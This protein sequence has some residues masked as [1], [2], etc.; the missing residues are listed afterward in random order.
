MPT[1][2]LST[3]LDGRVNTN[4]VTYHYI[5]WNEIPGRSM[6]AATS[7]TVPA[8]ATTTIETSRHRRLHDRG[9]TFEP[10]YVIVQECQRRSLR[11][12]IRRRSAEPPTRRSFLSHRLN[13]GQSDPER[14]RRTGSRSATTADVNLVNTNATTYVYYAWKRPDPASTGTLTAV[15]LTAFDATRYDRGVL[16][17]W[18]TGYEIDNLG[19]HVYREIDGR[20]DA[21]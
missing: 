15:R 2:S 13:A 14:S 9:V 21:A 11:F 3:S 19:F 5:A 1:A 7:A 12:T 20:A 16:L 8:P 6:S 18:R 17:Q 4:G 10:E